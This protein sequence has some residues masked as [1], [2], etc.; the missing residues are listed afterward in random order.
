MK[1]TNKSEKI[2]RAIINIFA[3]EKCTVNESM[4]ILQY[5]RGTIEH[6]STVQK[7]NDMLFE[8]GRR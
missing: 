4:E 7:V 1:A 2:A 5:V 8:N 3:D 6:H